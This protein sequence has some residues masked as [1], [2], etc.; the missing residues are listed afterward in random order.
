MANLVAATCPKCGAHV[1]LDPDREFVTCQFCG[2][3]SFI[4][5]QKRPVTQQVHAQALPVIHVPHVQRGCASAVALMAG[6][7]GVGA[8]LAGIVAAYV[9]SLATNVVP[10]PVSFKPQSTATGAAEATAAAR[11][12]PTGK[13]VEEDY[14]ADGTRVKARYEQALGKPVMAKQLVVYQYYAMLEAQNPK[15]RE[16]VDSYKLWANKVERPEAVRLGSDKKQLSQLL[17]SFDSIDFVLLQKLIKQ[18]LNE[19]A[20]EEG[21]VTHVILERDGSSAGREPIWRIYVNGSRDSGFVEF[22]SQGEK[23]RVAQ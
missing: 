2:A 4:Q 15:N 11:D 7:A 23:R 8:A 6:L 22:S 21:K 14:F 10:Q 9:S 13:L 18:A 20:I 17:F 1:R 5:T 16:H 12:E 19:L 3:S